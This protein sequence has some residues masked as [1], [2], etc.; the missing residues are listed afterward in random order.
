MKSLALASVSLLFLATPAVSADLDGP[1]YREREA[2]IE[3]PADRV[4][5]EKRVIEHRHYYEPAPV[6]SERY[7]Y[8]DAPVYNAG[9]Y[10]GRPY[11]Y[12]YAYGP[13]YWRPRHFFAR[14]PYW[15]RHHHW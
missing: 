5:V 7:Y 6:Y 1:V 11:A 10:Y 2:Y 4:I 12:R 3:R 9:Y 15:R 14:G 8:D 13:D